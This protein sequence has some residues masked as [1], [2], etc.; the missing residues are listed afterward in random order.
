MKV[1]EKEE[2]WLRRGIK[3]AMWE[4]AEGPSLNKKG[5][6]RF[7]LSHTYRVL[8]DVPGQLSIDTCVFQ[9]DPVET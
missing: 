1:L 8:Q 6:L 9:A 3:E 4:K 5:G 2:N 7:V